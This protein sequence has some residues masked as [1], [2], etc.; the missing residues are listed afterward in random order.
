MKQ[1][2]FFSRCVAIS[3]HCEVNDQPT[4]WELSFLDISQTPMIINL[5]HVMPHRNYMKM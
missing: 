2:A 5:S 4:Y 1:M 3:I